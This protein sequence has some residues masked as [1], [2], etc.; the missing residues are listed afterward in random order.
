MKAYL[1]FYDSLTIFLWEPTY[2]SM[3]AYLYFYDSLPMFLL[4]G[5]NNEIGILGTETSLLLCP[6]TKIPL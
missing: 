2:A 6:S 4:V 3:K 1:C 5:L